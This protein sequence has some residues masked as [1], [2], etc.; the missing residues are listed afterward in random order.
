MEKIIKISNRIKVLFTIKIENTKYNESTIPD[1]IN[2][3]KKK[4]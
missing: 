1:E 2:K 3:K 4:I